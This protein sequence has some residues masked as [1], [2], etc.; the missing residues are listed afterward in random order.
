[1]TPAWENLVERFRD[2]PDLL[3]GHLIISV[4]ALA[5]GAAISLPLGVFSAGSKR[6]SGIAL[7]LAATIQTVPSLALLALMVP[8]I[9]GII[10]FVPAYIALVL[11]SVLPMLRNTIT[12]VQGTDPDLVEAARGVGMTEMQALWRVRLPLAAPVIVAGIRTA[13]VWVVGMATLATAVGAPGLGNYIFMGLQTRNHIATLFGCFFAAL[14][15][16][17]LDQLIRVLERGLR[18]R[19]SRLVSTSVVAL[20]LLVLLG[21]LPTIL[22]RFATSEGPRGGA[23][24]TESGRPEGTRPLEGRRIVT[25]SKPFTESYILAELLARQLE[26][27][28]ADVDNRPNMGSSILFDALSKNSVDCYIDYSGTIWATVMKRD[29]AASRLEVQ[30]EVAKHLK[31]RYGIICVGPLGFENAYCL[32]MARSRARELGVRSIADLTPRAAG[33]KVG[34]DPEVFGRPEWTRV[35]DTYGLAGIREVGMQAV[36]MYNAVRDGQ[37]DIITAYSTDGRISEYDLVVLEDPRQTFPPYDA[38]L[39]VSP[40]AAKVPGLIDALLP[41]VNHIDDETMREANKWVEVEGLSSEKAA[42][43]L[44]TRIRK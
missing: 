19:R 11:Y 39:L 4:S 24:F 40:D 15:A 37:V 43:R 22:G 18:E 13:T 12:G 17:V 9:G 36:Y 7:T 5:T 21:F 38:I 23:E 28:G 32:V 1:M 8:L 26:A 31:D 25:G 20:A 35:H 41:L 27:A 2:L 29:E 16:I 3:G 6:F 10:G 33:L 30:I 34:G 44:W 42:E 14:L